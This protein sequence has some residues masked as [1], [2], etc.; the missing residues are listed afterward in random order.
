MANNL[1]YFDIEKG[2]EIT[3]EG[4]S[5]TQIR[6]FVVTGAP[7][8]S[9]DTATAEQGSLA[10][11]YNNGDFYYKKE[12]SSG[13][14]KW[15]KVAN[16][17]DVLA[18][19]AW[20]EPVKSTDAT[21]SVIGTGIGATDTINGITINPGDRV[22]FRNVAL[23]AIYE[24]SS[25]SG[26]TYVLADGVAEPGD[27]VYVEEGT[28]PNLEAGNVYTQNAAGAWV[29][30]EKASDEKELG[31][32]RQF[33]GKTAIGDTS[34]SQP[35]YD[36]V[37]ANLHHIAN[38]DVLVEA[39]RKLDSQIGAELVAGNV[40]TANQDTNAAIQAL[41]TAIGDIGAQVSVA[42]PAAET[43]YVVDSVAAATSV[44]V[45][46]IV[47]A[48]DGVNV[49]EWFVTAI[50]DGA[51]GEAAN[52]DRAIRARLVLGSLDVTVGVSISGGG[53]GANI[54][55]TVTNTPA[56]AVRILRR[57]VKF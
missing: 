23:N 51:P 36:A 7:G 6:V 37:P 15:R 56:V 22:L 30:S 1:Q 50:H 5:G 3:P 41:D 48:K 43:D 11:D 55:L 4:V 24:F 31:Y 34:A 40:V 20:Q 32:I 8:V 29:V 14:D 42:V 9:G 17:T 47:V 53:G 33:I 27:R 13:T 16:T 18:D 44:A 57:V 49:R 46:W 12:A 2:L 54:N 45:E 10:L 35:I 28:T 21:T 25:A 19:I 39:V 38:Q 26:G 52:T